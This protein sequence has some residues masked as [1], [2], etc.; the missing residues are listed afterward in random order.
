MAG[1]YKAL[2]C[3]RISKTAEEGIEA[4]RL[5]DLPRAALRAG[6]ARVAVHSASLNFPELLML[7]N[8]YQMKPQLPFVLTTEGAG[9]LVELGPNAPPGL[10]V[11]DRVYFA[12]MSPGAC[13]E[14]WVGP[15]A[16][17][18]KMPDHFTYAEGAAAYM[19]YTTGYHALAQRGRLQK[20]EWL[21]VTGAAG[22]MGV[23]A[24][25]IGKAM[26]ARVIAA[27][28]SEEKLELCRRAGADFT[29]NYAK[30]PLKKAV[31][32]ITKGKFC[33]V[34][35]EPVGGDIFDQCVRCVATG[36]GARLLVVGFAAGRIP[37]LPVNM[38]LI[39]GFDLVGV[40]SGHQLAFDAATR[41]DCMRGINE[42]I[43]NKG[44]KPIVTAEFPLAKAKDAFKLM[45][46][47]QVLGK[48]CITLNETKGKL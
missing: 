16:Q 48:V 14:E 33:D 30:E 36:G 40:R 39:K 27:A 5:V 38:C 10:S 4:I 35:Y 6:Q 1:T 24:V 41:Q 25:Q 2:M 7:Q 37:Q 45:N 11:G 42:L 26:G 9:R 8:K 22:G 23:A 13:S 46:E 31:A 44:L 43:A 32:K 28:S 29:V 15:A 34:I 18:F 47:R 19:G 3:E 21:M 17:C 12:S 20:G